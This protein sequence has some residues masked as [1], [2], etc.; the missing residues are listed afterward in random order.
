LAYS[1]AG[2]W[3]NTPETVRREEINAATIATWKHLSGHLKE[4]ETSIHFP[5][6]IVYE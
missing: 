4:K 5:S 3:A 6:S 1:G 2:D